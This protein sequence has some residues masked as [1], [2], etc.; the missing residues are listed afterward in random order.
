VIERKRSGEWENEKKSL[1]KT[2]N[3]FIQRKPLEKGKKL[4]S[5]S[6]ANFIFVE[7]VI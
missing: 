6:L 5:F 2:N 1:K 3:N 7:R 4:R